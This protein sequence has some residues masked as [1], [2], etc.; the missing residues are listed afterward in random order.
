MD[1]DITGFI[2]QWLERYGLYLPAHVIDFALDV[3]S[4]AEAGDEPVVAAA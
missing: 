2:D 4:M 3:R 1:G